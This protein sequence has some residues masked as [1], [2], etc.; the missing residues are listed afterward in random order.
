[1]KLRLKLKLGSEPSS[2]GSKQTAMRIRVGVQLC[3]CERVRL[4]CVC[5]CVCVCAFSIRCAA[6]PLGSMAIIHSCLLSFPL[7]DEHRESS[8]VKKAPNESN[9][10]LT[11]IESIWR[12]SIINRAK[13]LGLCESFSIR[14]VTQHERPKTRPSL[15]LRALV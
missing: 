4:D 3:V 6:W 11:L 10:N 15:K 14:G 7:T 2:S 1:M 5:L 8:Q 13:F 12:L 9:L